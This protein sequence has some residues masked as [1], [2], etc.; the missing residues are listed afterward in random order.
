MKSRRGRLPRK[1]SSL[2]IRDPLHGAITVDAEDVSILD[3]PAVQR[4][5]NIRQLGFAE[6]AF[7]GGT[8]SRFIHSVGA[9]W[10]ATRMWDSVAE[11][12]PILLKDK[13][14]LRRLVRLAVLLHD[15]GHGPMSHTSEFAMPPISALT[16][17]GEDSERQADH[18]DYTRLLLLHSSLKDTLEKADVA[19]TD[20][21]ALIS[22]R[23]PEDAS[24][25]MAG[26]VDVFPLMR[27]IVSSELDADRMDYLLRD[28]FFSGVAYGNFDLDWLIRSLRPVEV[29][30]AFHLGLSS[31]ALFAFEDFLLS[32]YHMFFSVYFHHKGVC[33]QEMLSRYYE[34]EPEAF[35]LPTTAE[36]YLAVD[37]LEWTL[38]LRKSSNPW[39]RRINQ[40]ESFRLLLELVP[41]TEED[42]EDAKEFLTQLEEE[43][44]AAGIECIK[45]ESRWVLSGYSSR[46]KRPPLF[47]VEEPL[48]RRRRI[49]EAS[50]LFDRYTGTHSILRLFC[51][52]AGYRKAYQ[53]LEKRYNAQPEQRKFDF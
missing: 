5:R 21:E 23:R 6:V 38:S 14:R 20:I 31:K 1:V 32:R 19:P 12:M 11:R 30:G 28:S 46:K 45:A 24:A 29:E 42:T 51:E 49:Q 43:L 18:E 3:H 33:F 34:E 44:K 35:T 15:I 9:M 41:P 7:P 17:L 13:K 26:D 22:G 47:S 50:A 40:R 48:G 2:S 4:L 16:A 37:D 39:A 25:F 53:L 8:H 36:E 10:V 52:P 27:Q